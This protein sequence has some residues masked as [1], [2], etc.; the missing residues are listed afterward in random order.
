MTVFISCAEGTGLLLR[1]NGGL[2]QVDRFTDRLLTYDDP[3]LAKWIG[4][5]LA[6]PLPAHYRIEN[7]PDRSLTASLAST[8][9]L[10]V[11]RH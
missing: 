4:I 11:S 2:L 10:T 9:L 1:P 3:D 6:E 5:F 8:S 7:A